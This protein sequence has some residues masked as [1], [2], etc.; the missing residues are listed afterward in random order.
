MN[1]ETRENTF[2]R[3]F[4]KYGGLY[5]P[6][7]VPIASDIASLFRNLRTS[8]QALINY[9]RTFETTFPTMP[10]VYFDFIANSS[11]NGKVLPVSQDLEL[12]GV[13]AGIVITF[14]Y[15]FN[16]LLA[17]PRIFPD[18][19]DPE[20]EQAPH[21][22]F[23][24]LPTAG[25]IVNGITSAGEPVQRYLPVHINRQFIARQMTILATETLI[26]HELAHLRFG[27]YHCFI[28]KTD[29]ADAEPA[30]TLTRQT[31]ESHADT[32][33]A[34]H[35]ADVMLHWKKQGTSE[36]GF[37][38]GDR[39][40]DLWI[41]WLF[42][43]VVIFNVMESATSETTDKQSDWETSSYPPARVRQVI[44]LDHITSALKKQ[45]DPLLFFDWIRAI[46]IA[47][48]IIEA[49]MPVLTRL[50][51]PSMSAPGLL[52]DLITSEG[53]IEDGINGHWPYVRHRLLSYTRA[54]LVEDL[55][56]S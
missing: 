18:I 24:R 32:Y 44:V 7:D 46:P 1:D 17:D 23:V 43:T 42:V 39:G 30:S 25:E 6:E 13:Y 52:R 21:L 35:R 8:G 2:A 26:V 37:S 12:I 33:A 10:E 50:F 20:I 19:S 38:G 47:Q 16:A 40:T 55:Q 53:A 14:D 36:L 56:D 5:Y 4:G 3:L 41:L 15:V 45:A 51:G 27:H 22:N 31:L 11:F 34:R 28:A 54:R 48:S 29:M 49:Q 9:H